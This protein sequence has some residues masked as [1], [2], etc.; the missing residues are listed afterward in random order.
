MKGMI[1]I[2]VFK[3]YRNQINYEDH[4]QL[5][6]AFSV[7]H[8]NYG[9]SPRFNQVSIIDMNI[10]SINSSLVSGDK[11]EGVLIFIHSSGGSEKDFNNED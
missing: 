1:I 5:D 4:L 7:A 8:I 6:G 3:K 10:E 2:S 11:I 9:K